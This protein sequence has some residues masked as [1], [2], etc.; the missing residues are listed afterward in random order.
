MS[1]LHH[2]NSYVPFYL[3]KDDKVGYAKPSVV[4]LS[5]DC[6][7]GYGS[8]VMVTAAFG[9]AAVS[10]GIELVIKTRDK[11]DGQSTDFFFLIF[12]LIHLL[13]LLSGYEKKTGAGFRLE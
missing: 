9:F 4:D 2:Q 11:Q 1:I 13:F 10:K 12:S 3:D 6:N 8:S 7:Y 5:M